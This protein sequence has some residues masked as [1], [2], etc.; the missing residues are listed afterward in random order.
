MSKVW[1]ITGA[2]AGFG[3]V[4]AEIVLKHGHQVIAATRDPE[5]AAL[6]SPHIEEL[7]GKWMKLDVSSPST[8]QDVDNAIKALAGDRIDV[9]VN[10]AGFF[11]AGGVED[12]NEEEIHAQFN[13]NLYGSIRTIQ[14]VLPFMRAQSSGI[15]VNFSSIAA[16]DGLPSCSLYAGSKYALEGFSESLSREVE[17]FGIRVLLVEPGAFRTNFLAGFSK[18]AAGLNPAYKG[19]PLDLILQK[20]HGMDQK[21]AGDPLKGCEI[22]YDVVTGTGVGEGK[23][24]LLRLPIGPDFYQRADDKLSSLKEN[25]DAFRTVGVMTN[26]D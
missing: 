11:M 15:I 17:C 25:I 24:H 22:I 14:A 4:L 5:A 6:K 13:I 2:S 23:T 19:T 10:N 12:F 9:L 18:A 20:F 26:F 21:Q 3:L 16:L 7:G 8:A 1:L